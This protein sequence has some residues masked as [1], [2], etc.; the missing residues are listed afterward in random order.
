MS[1]SKEAEANEAVKGWAETIAYWI[2]GDK[3]TRFPR[4]AEEHTD[5]DKLQALLRDVEMDRVM[6]SLPSAPLGPEAP[7]VL[8]KKGNGQ[9]KVRDFLF[10]AVAGA[11]ALTEIAE[12][13]RVSRPKPAAASKPET[14]PGAGTAAGDA[15]GSQPVA[16]ASG[17]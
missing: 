14:A 13:R 10:F 2:N 11:Q 8:A 7:S 9:E 17:S 12:G 1:K 15:A 16:A 6:S 4:F 3:A 5:P